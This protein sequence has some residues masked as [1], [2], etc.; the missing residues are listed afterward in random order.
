MRK[1]KTLAEEMA[2][3]SKDYSAEVLAISKAASE[4]HYATRARAIASVFCPRYLPILDAMVAYGEEYSKAPGIDQLICKISA[5]AAYSLLEV[6]Q[7]HL[8]PLIA[9]GLDL[10]ALKALGL[11]HHRIFGSDANKSNK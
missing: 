2:E 1:I 3:L 10:T 8:V 11:E 7:E 5:S 6:K 4:G 9:W